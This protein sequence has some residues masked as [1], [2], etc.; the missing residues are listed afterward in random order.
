ME[1]LARKTDAMVDSNI[2]YDKLSKIILQNRHF[3]FQPERLKHPNQQDGFDSLCGWW[4][5]QRNH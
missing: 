5:D 2:G 3:S 4:N 1:L